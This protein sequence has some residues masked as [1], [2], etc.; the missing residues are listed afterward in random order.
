ML[1]LHGFIRL[2]RVLGS[3]HEAPAPPR[4]GRDGPGGRRA[5]T[6]AG[7]GLAAVPVGGPGERRRARAHA[8]DAAHLGPAVCHRV[9]HRSGTGCRRPAARRLGDARREL[10]LV[11]AALHGLDRAR[12]RR[13]AGARGIARRRPA[14]QRHPAGRTRRVAPQALEQ[15]HPG[16]RGRPVD[17]RVVRHAARAGRA[18]RAGALDALT[19]RRAL[20]PRERRLVFGGRR[21]HARL[22]RH[23]LRLPRRSH[24]GTA[25]RRPGLH[26]H[27]HRSRLRQDHAAADARRAALPRGGRRQRLPDCGDRPPGAGARHLGVGAGRGSGHRPR[28][29]RRPGL[30]VGAPGSGVHD[31][32][33]RRARHHDH[34][35]HRRR[36]PAARSVRSRAA[37]T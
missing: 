6:G 35:R 23:A 34:P 36:H 21:L 16:V 12:E 15:R 37:G 33:K 30:H 25:L 14:G 1:D 28:P 29:R 13:A 8:A 31:R 17:R 9:R 18:L 5:D 4:L 27:P 26:A 32:Q 24:L 22:A 7:A 11:R 19:R 10:D 20:P 2:F 3:G